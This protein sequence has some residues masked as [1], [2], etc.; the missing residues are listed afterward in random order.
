MNQISIRTNKG[1]YFA[2]ETIYG[3]VYLWICSP[4]TAQDIKLKLKGYEKCEWEY[5]QQ[6]S[7]EGPDGNVEWEKVQRQVKGDKTFF[8]TEFKLVEYH[9]GIPIGHY[10]YPFQYTLQQE[11]PGTFCMKGKT[12]HSSENSWKANIKYKVKAAMES[13]HGK[14]KESQP[15]VIRTDAARSQINQSETHEKE[16]TVRMCCCIPRGTVKLKTRLDSNVYVAGSTAKVHVDVDNES[17]VDIENFVL[18]L[19]QVIHL[20]GKDDED[21]TDK[22]ISLTNTV[23]ERKYDGCQAGEKKECDIDLSLR[24]E[25]G[26]EIQPTTKGGHI[27][28]T[29]HIDIEMQVNWAP[30]IEIHA[31][32]TLTAPSNNYWQQWAAPPWLANCQPVAVQGACA[33]PQPIMNSQTFS[34]VPGFGPPI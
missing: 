7:R 32:I 19:M 14:L 34:N 28:C 22:R 1:E 16:G 3:T 24:S 30:D 25:D 4:T 17:A 33:V 13:H 11:I 5:T 12:P 20:R 2:G 26:K 10:A 8:K 29:Y 23:C 31:P 18:K 15:L 6:V 21:K 27:Q 9:D